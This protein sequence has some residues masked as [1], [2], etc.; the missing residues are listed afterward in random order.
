MNELTYK[1]ALSKVKIL[2][3]LL[4]CDAFV[5]STILATLFEK[6]KVEVMNDIVRVLDM[7]IA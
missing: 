1:L 2:M 4:K 7:R 5:I 6:D 3:D